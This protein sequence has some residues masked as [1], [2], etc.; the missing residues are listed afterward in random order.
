MLSPSEIDI[1]NRFVLTQIV[2]AAAGKQ[3]ALV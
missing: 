1:E 3:L 2:Y